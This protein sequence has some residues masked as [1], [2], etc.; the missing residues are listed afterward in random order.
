MVFAVVLVGCEAICK[1]VVW[2]VTVYVTN[3]ESTCLFL[4]GDSR[5]NKPDLTSRHEICLNLPQTLTI[6]SS[7]CYQALYFDSTAMFTVCIHGL[8]TTVN[9][10][11]SLCKHSQLWV[12]LYRHSTLE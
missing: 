12:N 6:C 5:V 3:S 11:S 10:S 1:C 4:Q 9:I 7:L 2:Y 8:G